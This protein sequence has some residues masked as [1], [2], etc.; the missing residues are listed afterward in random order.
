MKYSILGTDPE[1]KELRI[2]REESHPW[3]SSTLEMVTLGFQAVQPQKDC[4]DTTSKCCWALQGGV[5]P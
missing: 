2:M 1:I 3:T 4:R 5:Q